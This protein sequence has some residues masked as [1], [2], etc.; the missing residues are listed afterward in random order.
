[1]AV[2]DPDGTIVPDTVR[3]AGNVLIWQR[4]SLTIRLESALPLRTA[5]RIART[6]R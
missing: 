4:G 3:L 2:A 6:V 1:V 5:L